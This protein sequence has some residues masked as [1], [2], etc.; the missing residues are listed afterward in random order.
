M[1]GAGGLMLGVSARPVCVQTF[2]YRYNASSKICR[3]EDPLP[4]RVCFGHARGWARAFASLMQRCWVM[5]CM[6]CS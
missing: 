1:D 2:F 3:V 6:L 5:L 4:F